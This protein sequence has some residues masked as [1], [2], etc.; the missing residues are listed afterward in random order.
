[1]FLEAIAPVASGFDWLDPQQ[2]RDYLDEQQ[3]NL[4]VNTLGWSDDGK[5]T[6][7]SN[8]LSPLAVLIEQCT[9]RDLVLLQLSSY[10]VFDG[11]K[12]GF[13]ESDE[14]VPRDECGRLHWLAEQMAAQLPSHLILRLSWVVGASGENLLTHL[15]EPVV[16]G[17]T[18]AIV[19]ER[20]GSPV[21]HTDI[22]RVINALAKQIASGSENWGVFHYSAGDVCT[23]EEF[24]AE[25]C[26]RLADKGFDLGKVEDIS[27]GAADPI[28]A[29]LGY[30]RLMD[31]FGIQPRTWRQTLTAELNRWLADHPSFG[32]GI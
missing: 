4:I 24:A 5:L 30:R 25:L 11:T 2:V 28:S 3:P 31:N 9:H 12:S 29:A 14:V 23:E 10:R 27:G 21:G 19:G 16:A 1:M 26:Q 17:E 15:L 32:Q 7:E 6:T 13:V 22:A 18:A 20:R 8:L